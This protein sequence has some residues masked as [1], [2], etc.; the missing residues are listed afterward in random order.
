MRRAV[1]ALLF[2][3]G[4]FALVLA[5]LLRFYVHHELG[6]APLDPNSTTVSQGSGMTVFYPGLLK[7]RTDATVTA[8]RNIQGVLNA[9]EVKVDGDV[10]TWRVGLVLE[11][12][13]QVLVSAFDERVCVDR[14]S[15]ETVEPCADENLNDDAIKHS[16]LAYKFPFNTAKKDYPYFDINLKDSTPPMTFD[17]EDMVNGLPVYRFVQQIPATKIEDREVPG[18]LV[19]GTPGTTVTAGRFYENTRTVWV[20]PYSGLI[21][22]GEEKVRQVL[23]G[24]DG[25]DGQVLLAGTIAF[26]QDTVRNQV[27]DAEDAR[28]QL[29]M[30]YSTGPLALT[31]AGVVLLLIGA[32]LAFTG[33]RNGPA[34][35]PAA[36]GGSAHRRGEHKVTT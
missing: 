32:L 28:G 29:R 11:D 3:L 18:D 31:I 23:R 10:A 12:D 33:R 2:A 14:R 22:K 36:A 35:V 13:D 6:V 9:P 16:G 19:N 1:T 25:S 7:T 8:T 17:G 30:V 24:P 27:A 4:A 34:P 21:V 20:E 26:T 5:G 15:A